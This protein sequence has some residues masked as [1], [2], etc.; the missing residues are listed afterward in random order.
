MTLYLNVKLAKVKIT[1][2]ALTKQMGSKNARTGKSM[3]TNRKKLHSMEFD[4]QIT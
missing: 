1:I 3:K 2:I 4:K